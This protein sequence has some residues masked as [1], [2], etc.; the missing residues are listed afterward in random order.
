ME[1]IYRLGFD[2]WQGFQRGTK[3]SVGIGEHAFREGYS[4]KDEI[5]DLVEETPMHWPGLE[6]RASVSG[7]RQLS[8][9]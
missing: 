5:A 1:R 8:K 4:A 9:E 2:F 3:A 6:P 7:G